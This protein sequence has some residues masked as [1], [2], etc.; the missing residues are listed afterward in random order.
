MTLDQ[1][2]AEQ[3]EAYQRKNLLE[4]RNNHPRPNPNSKLFSKEMRIDN[5]KK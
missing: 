2:E 1:E 4:K 5:N 3:Q